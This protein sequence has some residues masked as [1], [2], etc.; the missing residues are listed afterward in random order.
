MQNGMRSGDQTL[1]KAQRTRELSSAYQTRVAYSA[2]CREGAS[3]IAKDIIF[4]FKGIFD[5]ERARPSLHEIRM[6]KGNRLCR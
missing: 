2:G 4:S 5:F 3:S 1:P 6:T